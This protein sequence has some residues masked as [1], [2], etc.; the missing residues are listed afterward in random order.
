MA[1]EGSADIATDFEVLTESNIPG[2]SLNGKKPKELNVIQLKR[3]L[4][5]RGAPTS[6]KKPQLIERLAAY[7]IVF[8][9][10]PVFYVCLLRVEH[11]NQCG[12]CFSYERNLPS[13]T[14]YKL[15]SIYQKKLL[16]TSI[17]IPEFFL[18]E[19][20]SQ[21]IFSYANYHK[22]KGKFVHIESCGLMSINH[23]LG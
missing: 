17:D 23:S 10:L 16:S 3:W 11:Y 5:C 19:N 1:S 4:S 8:N 20:G 12:Y 7:L 15:H 2:A 21:A 13:A 6:G 14:Q 22:C 9:T 18:E